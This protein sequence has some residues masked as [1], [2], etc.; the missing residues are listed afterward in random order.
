MPAAPLSG[1]RARQN[2]L[3]IPL[4]TGPAVLVGGDDGTKGTTGVPQQWIDIYTPTMAEETIINQHNNAVIGTA[5]PD[6]GT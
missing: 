2:H 1:F 6:G 4:E 3:A 5:T